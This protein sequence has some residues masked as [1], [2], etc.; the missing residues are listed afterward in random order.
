MKGFEIIRAV[1]LEPVPLDSERDLQEK[2]K[3]QEL[4]PF[5]CV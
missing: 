1:V 5:P 2:R 3:G 4:K